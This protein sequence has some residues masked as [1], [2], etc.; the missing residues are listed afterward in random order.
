M[1]VLI[2]TNVVI[3]ATFWPGKSKALMN[4]VRRGEI[5]YLTSEVLLGELREILTN[6]AKP[7]R[8]RAEEAGQVVEA[9]RALATLVSPTSQVSESCVSSVKEA[10]ALVALRR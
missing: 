4:A 5:T 6:Q 9:W 1:R 10:L 8:L 2:D 3:S 7:F